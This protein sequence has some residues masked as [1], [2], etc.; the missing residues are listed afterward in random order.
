MSLEPAHTPEAA[1]THLMRW[2]FTVLDYVIDQDKISQFRSEYEAAI[3]DGSLSYTPGTNQRV[4]QA[5]RLPTGRK[6]WLDPHVLD[7]LREW[8]RDEPCACQTL[9]Y[10]NGSEQDAHQDTIHLTRPSRRVSCAASGFAL[11]D[12]QPNSGRTS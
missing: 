2:G 9:L 12:V 6:I 10:I 1:R 8:F 5:H 3:D 7:F 4:H 11:Q